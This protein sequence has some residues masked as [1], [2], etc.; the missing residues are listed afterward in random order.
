MAST[1]SWFCSLT[2]C[3]LLAFWFLRSLC[4]CQVAVKIHYFWRTKVVLTMFL[5]TMFWKVYRI[6]VHFLWCKPKVGRLGKNHFPST[7]TRCFL[8]NSCR[9]FIAETIHCPV[10][11]QC[12]WLFYCVLRH[13]LV[14]CC[15]GYGFPMPVSVI[16]TNGFWF[17]KFNT[18]FCSRVL[19]LII[20]CL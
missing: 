15:C 1:F 12:I 18:P 13:Y 16:N 9:F 11:F 5:R 14:I 2:S 10:S 20:R 6:D 19:C 8:P 17:V 7:N 3:F 4:L